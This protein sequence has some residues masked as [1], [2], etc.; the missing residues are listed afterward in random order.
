MQDIFIR[1]RNEHPVFTFDKYE[2][3]NVNDK[4]IIKYYFSLGEFATFT[5][6]WEFNKK[7]ND[8]DYIKDAIV[9]RLAFNLGM[10][11]L[12]S[13]WKLACPPTVVIKAG[14]LDEEQLAWW[15]EQYYLG[16]GE[17][18]Y[19]NGINTDYEG[20]MNMKAAYMA[21]EGLDTYSIDKNINYIS[22]D[23]LNISHN[24]RLNSNYE[25]K[26]A[27]SGC[28]IPIGGGKDSIVTLELLKDNKEENLC[29]MIND[30]E[31][32]HKTALLAGYSEEQI[33]IV[34]RSLDQ[35]MLRLNKE[36][37]LNGHTPFS[38][39][40]AFS[41]V[42]TAYLNDK[43]Y[44]ALSN[45]SSANESTVEGTLVNHQYSKSF[46]FE[47]DFNSYEKKYI[48]SMVHYFSLLR[49]YTELQIAR[50][51]SKQERYFEIFRSCNVGSKINKWCGQCPKCLFVYIILSPFISE[52]KLTAI[53]GYNLLNNDNLLLTFNKLIGLEPEKPFECVGTCGEVNTALCMTI[54]SFEGSQDELP[55]LLRYYMHTENYTQYINDDIRAYTD[56]YDSD[57]N[58]PI[59]FAEK[60]KCL[61]LY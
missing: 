13:Y 57:N 10:V 28:L 12:I 9:N 59:E 49:P 50:F 27:L 38:A 40:V 30:K 4:L 31:A 36:G 20:F 32:S 44:V 18:F 39:I 21:S 14:Y 51:F 43:A 45:E 55:Y 25:A 16:L 58:V 15:K 6:A 41:S 2:I 23:S 35:N 53:F 26:R 46:K 37:F 22:D 7:H 11:E 5:P 1:L 3:L 17:F 19:T 33:I 34:K 52:D 48:G 42:L 61:M 8:R 29:Y 47:Q 24:S 60:A 56:Y 54:R